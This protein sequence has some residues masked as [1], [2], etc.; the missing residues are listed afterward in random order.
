MDAKVGEDL[1]RTLTSPNAVTRTVAVMERKRAWITA[2]VVAVTFTTAALAVMANTGLLAVS[3]SDRNVGRLSP[4]DI[5]I[6]SA[7]LSTTT[8][9]TPGASVRYE[10]V[11][12]TI[13]ADG[14]SPQPDASAV[15]TNVSKTAGPVVKR[16]AA[17][18]S[19]GHESGE[20]RDGD[21]DDD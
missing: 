21:G 4:V 3:P 10:D 2:G 15:L 1:T 16:R 17:P 13:P 11:Y 9:A 14:S 12:V 7:Q 6:G 8:T 18:A 20:T 5:T 19:V